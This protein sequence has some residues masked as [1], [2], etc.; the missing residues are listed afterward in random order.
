[1]V[2]RWAGNFTSQYNQGILEI[3]EEIF[4][5]LCFVRMQI[6]F[7]EDETNLFKVLLMFDTRTKIILISPVL[8]R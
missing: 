7:E 3:L 6:L 2:V 5:A 1:M 4:V 8:L